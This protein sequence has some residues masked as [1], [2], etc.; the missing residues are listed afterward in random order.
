MAPRPGRS[1]ARPTTYPD[2][3]SSPIVAAA[4]SEAE[5]AGQGQAGGRGALVGQDA[6]QCAAAPAHGETARGIG[7]AEA[8]REEEVEA[9]QED[10]LVRGHDHRAALEPRLDGRR[11]ARHRRGVQRRRRLVEQQ[12]GR[13][14][15]KRARQRQPL[16][17]AGAEGEAVVPEHRLQSRRQRG[18]ELGET[19]RVEDALHVGRRG[20]RCPEP[21]VVGHARVEEVRALGQ[22]GEDAPPRRDGHVVAGVLAEGHGPRAGLDEAQQRG[23][24]G[25]LARSGGPGQRDPGAGGREEGERGERR[26]V[27]VRVAD[28]DTS[29]RERCRV[30]ATRGRLRR[31]VPRRTD[32]R[33]VP[34]RTDGRVVPRRRRDR[35]VEDREHSGRGRLSLG[36]G[37][38][39][40]AGAAQRD[41]DLGRHEQDGHGRLQAELAPEQPQPEHH[42]DQ[43]DPEAGEHVHGQRRE[44]G[45]AQGAQGGGAHAVGGRRHL[46]PPVVLASEGPQ[47]RQA[48]D[49]LQEAAG[50]GPEPAPLAGRAFC[51]LASEQDHRERHREH[52]C[53]DHDK[54]QPVLGRHPGQ[55]QYRDHRGGCRLGEVARVVG[56]QGAQPPRGGERELSGALAGQ[57]A[58]TEGEGVAQQLAAQAGHDAV[59]RTL[60]R[61][62]S[63]GVQRGADQDGRA[64]HDD[65]GHDGA[66]G[67]VVQKGAVHHV[68]ERHRLDHH[69]DRAQRSEE[70]GERGHPPQAGNPRRELGLDQARP[71]RAR[72]GVAH[73]LNVVSFTSTVRPMRPS[74]TA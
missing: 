62:V 40:G 54:G 36:A 24:D 45:D 2:P 21:Q 14:A 68:G 52:Q 71:T 39:L 49:Q 59:G 26:D 23:E 43:A 56:V 46:A 15:E 42:R 70:E 57:P 31:V 28:P 22:P 25:R 7:T 27:P 5:K 64:D 72:G 29:H 17:F 3:A 41:E 12:H 4:D 32:G 44:E 13:R 50:Q 63:C 9:W 65:G 18:Q 10:R 67:G 48:L 66:E 61:E 19:D 55:E 1:A 53:D 16:A 47:R 73:R 37:V 30:R 34:R 8:E 69:R 51:R 35:G 11:Q 74:A 58:G 33:V 60:G 6:V 20:R 38:E